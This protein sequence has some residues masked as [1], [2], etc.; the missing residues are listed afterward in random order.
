MHKNNVSNTLENYLK[1]LNGS[2]AVVGNAVTEKEYGKEI[3]SHDHVIR[4]N[5]YEKIMPE[6]VGRKCTIWCAHQHRLEN[7][8]NHSFCISVKQIEYH[9]AGI[10][11]ICPAKD[12]YA[13][14]QKK[15]K[16][17]APTTGL[18]LLYIFNDL[19]I[20]VDVYG[21]DFLA[22]GHYFKKDF[23]HNRAHKPDREKEIITSM[24]Y[25][26]MFN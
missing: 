20:P 5:M 19:C 21:F 18:T 9:K 12:Y 4:F 14:I 11:C 3:D 23:K 26:W 8:N 2:I 6:I 16:Y 17:E 25:V 22:T 1:A 7:I 15:Y 13:E 24:Q 10:F